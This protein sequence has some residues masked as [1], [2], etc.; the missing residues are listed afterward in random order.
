MHRQRF[1]YAR[2]CPATPNSRSTNPRR[3]ADSPIPDDG[4]I[5]FDFEG[6][7]LWAEDGST[8]WGLEYLFGVVEGPA[9]DYVFKPFWAH[10]REGER[11]ALLDFLDYVTA[12]REAHPGMHIYTTP[13]TRNR[14]CC[15]WP[16]VTV[17]ASRPWTPCSART[18]SST[19]TRSSARACGSDNARTASRNS[20]RSTWVSTA[21]TVT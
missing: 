12:R 3:S 18:C 11:Q 10:D 19:C 8:D 5:F 13:R 16:H 15:A 6:D 2:N 1:N 9:D 4:D 17:S 14:R 7:P 21:V 20:S